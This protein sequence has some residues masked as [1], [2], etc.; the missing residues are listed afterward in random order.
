MSPKLTVVNN[1]NLNDHQPV[2]EELVKSLTHSAMTRINIR[3]GTNL[4]ELIGQE[5]EVTNTDIVS[6][7]IRRYL[8]DPSHDRR[9]VDLGVLCDDLY[10]ALLV[11]RWDW[12]LDYP[13]PG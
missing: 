10:G 7:W 5:N 9:P 2:P 12:V 1:S 11:A 4:A 8:A 6:D 13:A 3:N